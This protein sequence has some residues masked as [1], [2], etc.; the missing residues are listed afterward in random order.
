MLKLARKSIIAAATDGRSPDEDAKVPE[1]LRER[2]A[3]FVTLTKKGALRGCIG[4]HFSG[5]SAVSGSDSARPIGG[6][7]GSAIST[8]TRR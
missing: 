6:D 8:S 5:R 7:R 3:C 1:K 2:R 4:K